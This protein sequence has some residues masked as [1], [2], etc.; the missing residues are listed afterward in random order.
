MEP[1]A[2]DVKSYIQDTN[3]I[4]KKISNLPPLSNDLILCTIDIVGLYPNIR[5]EEEL[6]A[7]RKALDTRKDQTISTDYLIFNRVGRAF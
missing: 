6:I 4:L 5:H 2:Q 3:D 7:V 1:L